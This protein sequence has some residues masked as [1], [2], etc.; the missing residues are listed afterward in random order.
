MSPRSTGDNEVSRPGYRIH[1]FDHSPTVT[2][3]RLTATSRLTATCTT[4]GHECYLTD[5]GGTVHWEHYRITLSPVTGA[6]NG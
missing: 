5:L 2:E 1:E 6:H 3:R 4:C